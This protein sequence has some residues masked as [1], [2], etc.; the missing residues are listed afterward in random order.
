MNGSLKALGTSYLDVL[1]LHRPDTL[2]E[3]E[4]VARAFDELEGSGKVR[5]FGVSNHTPRQIDLLKTAVTQ[6]I[7]INQVQLSV[8]YFPVIAQGLTANTAGASDAI[9]TDGAGSELRPDQKTFRL[10][11]GNWNGWP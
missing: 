10:S 9:T 11:T 5:A 1:L 6:P 2:V 8:T 3:P 4:E 7:L